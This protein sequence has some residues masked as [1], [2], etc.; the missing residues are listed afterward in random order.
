MFTKPKYDVYDPC[1]M[2]HI[3]ESVQMQFPHL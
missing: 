2:G 1:D 3:I